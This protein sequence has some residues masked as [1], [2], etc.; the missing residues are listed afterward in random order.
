LNVTAARLI[1]AGCQPERGGFAAAGSADDA[2]EF[3]GP[4]AEVQTL[5]DGLASQHQRGIGKF[6]LWRGEAGHGRFLAFYGDGHDVTSHRAD[7]RS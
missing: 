5:D 3:A 4:D 6:D 2:E 1:E 7:R